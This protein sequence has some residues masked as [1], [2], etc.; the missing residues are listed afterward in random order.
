MDKEGIK[1]IIKQNPEL[2]DKLFCRGFLFTNSDIDLDAYPFFSIWKHIKLNN[3]HM[4]VSPKQKSYY[5]TN[6]DITIYLVGHAYNPFT[7]VSEENTILTELIEQYSE[8]NF[9]KVSSLFW[10]KINELTGIF[11]IIIIDKESVLIII[12]RKSVV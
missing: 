6:G 9:V 1:A 10:E 8:E 2:T 3:Y 4:I 7:M 11:T 12:D 5:V